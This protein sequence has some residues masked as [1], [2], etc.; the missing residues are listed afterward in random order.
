MSEGKLYQQFRSII[1]GSLEYQVKG[2]VLIL[3]GYYSGNSIKIDLDKITPEMLSEII[4]EEDP[5]EEDW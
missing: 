5:E 4:Y 1:H 3:R 2:G